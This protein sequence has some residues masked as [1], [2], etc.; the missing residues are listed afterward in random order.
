MAE[1]QTRWTVQQDANL[2][3]MVLKK[4]NLAAIAKKLKRSE[5]SV[6]ARAKLLRRGLSTLL[7]E[8]RI[9]QTSSR[10]GHRKHLGISVRSSW[11]ANFLTILN[12]QK[13]AWD[14]EPKMFIFHSIE[15]GTRGYLPD[16]Y[17]PE[18]DM[19]IEIKGRIRP[20]DKTK[21][22]RFKKYYPEEFSKFKCIVK[23]SKVE[24]AVF[25]ESIGVPV[26]AYYEDL[27]KSYDNLKNW[28]H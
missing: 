5:T 16:V 14:Y 15:R 21:L 2:V 26:Y 18:E 9:V 23:N 13:I 12:H 6:Q 22:R 27:Q 11:E 28:E 8:K 19:W 4:E 25:F 24:S 1:K 20:K 7:Q 17:L 10:Q 3:R